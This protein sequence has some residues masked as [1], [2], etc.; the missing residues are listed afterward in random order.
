M[1][2]KYE[3]RLSSCRAL[4]RSLSLS[5]VWLFICIRENW[6]NAIAR[7]INRV[8][9]FTLL[10]PCL[11]AVF[12]IFHFLFLPFLFGRMSRKIYLRVRVIPLIFLI[13]CSLAFIN[14]VCSCCRVSHIPHLASH[15]AYHA[16][17]VG[18]LHVQSAQKL[19]QKNLIK[20]NCI[21]CCSCCDQC[22]SSRLRASLCCSYPLH[23]VPSKRIKTLSASTHT[24]TDR[25]WLCV[26]QSRLSDCCSTWL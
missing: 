20:V 17:S 10:L 13:P 1:H 3:Q 8:P 6:I 24:H 15:I 7:G 21:V 2:S 18:F 9:L 12:I 11:S 23:C 14:F 19:R 4:L 26:L 22:H 5:A 25:A 16:K